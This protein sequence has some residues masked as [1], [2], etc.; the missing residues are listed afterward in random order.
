MGSSA[1]TPLPADANK[2]TDYSSV[3]RYPIYLQVEFN[4]WL[5]KYQ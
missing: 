2:N 4:Y 1:A 3:G 5:N